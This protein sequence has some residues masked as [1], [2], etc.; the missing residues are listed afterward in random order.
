M[1]FV[2]A[3]PVRHAGGPKHEGSLRVSNKSLIINE[4]ASLQSPCPTPTGAHKRR[5]Y[6]WLSKIVFGMCC[7]GQGSPIP[8]GYPLM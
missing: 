8:F 6:E 4:T 5:P 3:L 2:H 1:D 7:A